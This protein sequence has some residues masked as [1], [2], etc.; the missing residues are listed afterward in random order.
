MKTK[1]FAE[2]LV[3]GM[4]TVTYTSMFFFGALYPGY[5]IPSQSIV[6]EED[7]DGISPD[8]VEVQY[9]SLLWEQLKEWF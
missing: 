9:K 2:I 1:W 5:G 8:D 7:G 3:Y 6:Y 4:L